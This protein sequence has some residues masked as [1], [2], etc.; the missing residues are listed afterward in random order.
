MHRT[1]ARFWSGLASLPEE[2][3]RV[4]RQNFALLKACAAGA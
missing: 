1:T 3:Q 2:V 4:A